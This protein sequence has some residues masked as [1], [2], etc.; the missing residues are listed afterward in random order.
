MQNNRSKYIRNPSF[1]KNF[2]ADKRYI[3]LTSNYFNQGC[4]V[5]V[6]ELVRK[7]H[8]QKSS[9]YDFTYFSKATRST[10]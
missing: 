4:P 7:A 2:M 3:T 1:L 6:T 9:I 10:E 8:S 5:L